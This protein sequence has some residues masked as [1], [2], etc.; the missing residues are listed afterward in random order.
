MKLQHTSYLEG[1]IKILESGYISPPKRV[2]LKTWSVDFLFWS[3]VNNDVQ[4]SNSIYGHMN[5][6][7]KFPRHFIH[8]TSNLYGILSKTRFKFNRIVSGKRLF[9]YIEMFSKLDKNNDGYVTHVQLDHMLKELKLAKFEN[10]KNIPKFD[11][12]AC[13]VIINL[14]EQCKCSWEYI[15]PRLATRLALEKKIIK[16]ECT[17]KTEDKALS[18][19]LVKDA[20]NC[21]G[22]NE[23][24]F[25]TPI[26]VKHFK[27]ITISVKDFKKLSDAQ[28]VKLAGLLNFY[29]N[30]TGLKV[31]LM[32][33]GFKTKP[34]TKSKTKPKTKPKTKS[35]LTNLLSVV[36]EA[37]G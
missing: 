20:D 1:I 34:K 19:Y 9:K 25:D 12:P 27:Y 16:H 24:G 22:G 32:E 23:I 6:T 11:F 8:P 26:H 13:V 37:F 17:V 31:V 21:D 5:L 33:S 35:T 18:H 2:G 3:V 28:Q 14:H 15:S 36:K 29:K 30:K 7:E 10:E 4:E